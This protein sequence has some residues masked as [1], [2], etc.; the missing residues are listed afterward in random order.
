MCTVVIMQAYLVG[1]WI[2]VGKWWGFFV[3]RKFESERA[4]FQTFFQN[5]G[6]TEGEHYQV[7]FKQIYN[8]SNSTFSKTQRTTR[9]HFEYFCI[10]TTFRRPDGR[11][12]STKGFDSKNEPIFELSAFELVTIDMSLHF[13]FFFWNL[14]EIGVSRAPQGCW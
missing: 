12:E 14:I 2:A 9:R 1:C 11:E 4:D 7:L 13:H 10:L 5:G 8:L 3:E 6:G